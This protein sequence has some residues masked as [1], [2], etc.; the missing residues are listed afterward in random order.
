MRRKEMGANNHDIL[1][2]DFNQH[3]HYVKVIF[4]FSDHVRVDGLDQCWECGRG[5]EPR[6]V[7]SATVECE[8]SSV[9]C[10]FSDLIAWM[11]AITCVV[12]QCSFYWEGEGPNGSFE[13]SRGCPGRLAVSCNSK[14]QTGKFSVSISPR[15]AIEAIYIPFIRFIGSNEYHPLAY[16]NLALGGAVGLL[17]APDSVEQFTASMVMAS[18]ASADSLIR[19]VMDFAFKRTWNDGEPKTLTLSDLWA[20]ASSTQGDGASE[21]VAKEWDG[22]D[23]AARTEDVRDLLATKCI[24]QGG[25]AELRNLRSTKIEEWLAG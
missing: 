19:A 6:Y 20:H 12:K 7:D 24:N 23:T 9:F 18:R 3:G 14:T 4:R 15:E 17:L 5:G 1:R 11:E 21:W 2:V 16:E 13:W 10:P 25:G 22:M 8:V